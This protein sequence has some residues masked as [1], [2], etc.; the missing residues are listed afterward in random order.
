MPKQGY[1]KNLQRY[2][3][4]DLDNQELE[5]L[6]DHLMRS[7]YDNDRQHKWAK[8]LDDEYQVN[9][10]TIKSTSYSKMYWWGIG[11]AAAAA[12][13]FLV[14]PVLNTNTASYQ[15]AVDDLLTAD[16]YE[17]R[18]RL[19]GDQ[20][21]NR[22]NILAVN[23]YNEKDFST[24]IEYY[25]EIVETGLANDEHYFF[26][27]LSHLYAKHY[28]AATQHLK[29]VMQVNANSKFQ[30]ET[31]WF[32]ALAYLKQQDVELGRNQLLQIKV[33]EWN[34]QKAQALLKLIE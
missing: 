32:L 19:K 16:F 1:M 12:V 5:F 22:L 17:N 10:H 3:D 26:L 8:R 11:V 6:T 9:R 7:K 13:L 24:A 28:N 27:G 15:Q 4:E 14:I 2:R 34:Y 31:R 29:E 18:D 20:D 23:A 25:E 21:I 33:K 30:Q